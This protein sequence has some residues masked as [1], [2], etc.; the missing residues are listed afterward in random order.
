M[1]NKNHFLSF[2]FLILYLHSLE[3]VLPLMMRMGK[4]VIWLKQLDLRLHTR[5]HPRNGNGYLQRIPGIFCRP[6]S[7]VG[8][9]SGGSLV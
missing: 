3:Q 1:A 4:Y 9:A 2:G 7:L 6:G 8:T 5:R